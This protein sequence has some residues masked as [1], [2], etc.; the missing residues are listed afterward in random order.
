[1][2]DSLA[3][4]ALAPSRNRLLAALPSSMLAALRPLLVPVRLTAPQTLHV[5][6][7]PVAAVHFVETGFVSMVARLKDGTLAEVRLVGRE[8]M[9]GLPLALCAGTATTEA[10]VL[11]NGTALRLDAANLAREMAGNGPLR[12]VL[13]RYA[14]AFQAQVAQTA[15]RNGRHVPEE[16]L[17][18]WLLMAHDRA[19]GD[20]LPVSQDFVAL[21][22]GVRRSGVTVA[23]GLLQKV[24]LV[25]DVRGSISILD[26]A[27]LEAAACDCHAAV[28]RDY[29]RLFPHPEAAPRVATAPT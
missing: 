17:A 1:M 23:A 22:L 10:M 19:A 25:H 6:G 7:E 29:A 14:L 16:G 2:P 27:G 24:G 28:E 26:R 15:A 8:G 3:A 21:M 11:G 12:R 5:G 9:V 4:Q 13:L 18:R 20:V